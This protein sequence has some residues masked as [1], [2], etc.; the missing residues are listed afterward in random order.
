MGFDPPKVDTDQFREA[1]EVTQI[2]W[3]D[4]QC[5]SLLV[6]F[7]KDY[8]RAQHPIEASEFAGSAAFEIL[9]TIVLLFATAGAG[10]A[11]H[12]AS[13]GRLIRQMR[14]LGERLKELAELKREVDRYTPNT[15]I[16]SRSSGNMVEDLPVD[17]RPVV[18]ANPPPSM[19]T[20]VK[21][22]PEQNHKKPLKEKPLESDESIEKGKTLQASIT[23]E[24]V[25]WNTSGPDGLQVKNPRDFPAGE[26]MY[27][28]LI[29]KGIEPPYR[30]RY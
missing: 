13:K 24:Q 10:V 26:K 17:D 9:L 27:N 4:E 23:P 15:S 8:Y 20:K 29:D 11:I 18:R 5:Q 19:G 21:S 6:R 30:Q 2:I 28:H 14:Q 16:S 7:A 12:V 22:D 1:W 3:D 25:D